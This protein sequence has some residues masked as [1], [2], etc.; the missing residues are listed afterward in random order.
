MR[1]SRGNERHETRMRVETSDPPQESRAGHTLSNPWEAARRVRGE[2][3]RGGGEEG[4]G[5][6]VD[7]REERRLTNRTLNHGSTETVSGRDEPSEGEGEIESV[8]E[9]EDWVRLKHC[10]KCRDF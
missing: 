4:G 10:W 9:V 2:E 8:G 7:R 5:E 3:R 1:G 6:D